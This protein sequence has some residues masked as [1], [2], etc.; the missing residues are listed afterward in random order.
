MTDPLKRLGLQKSDDDIHQALR[1]FEVKWQRKASR[2]I[3]DD[4]ISR[5]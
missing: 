3:A 2:T 4:R 5:F 1:S